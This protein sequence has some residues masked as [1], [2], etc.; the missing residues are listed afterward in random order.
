[1]SEP[2]I[3]TTSGQRKPIAALLLGAAGIIAA[4]M[5]IGACDSVATAYDCQQVCQRYAD[6]YNASFDVGKCR[7]MCRANAEDDA[8]K[9]QKADACESCIGDK[10]CLSATFTCAG[11][12]AG[13]I[14]P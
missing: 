7:D 11:D 8:T 9:M 2:Q 6:C 12:C 14:S 13:V 1:M 5:G 4:A 3:K 10:S